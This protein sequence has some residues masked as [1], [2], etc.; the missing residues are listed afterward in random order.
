[1]AGRRYAL[2]T[3]A[4]SGIGAAMTRL[5]AARG[6]DVAVVAR[7][8]DRLEALATELRASGTGTDVYAADLSE[9]GGASVL[10][11]RINE[12][13]RQP[14]MLI[15]NAG[16]T[17][18]RGYAGTTWP[19]QR[20][21]LE[22]TVTTPALLTHA[23]LAAMLQ[24]SW[25][26]IVNISSIAALS[27]GG[28]GNTL[29]PAGKSFLLK[30]SQSLSAEVKARGVHVTAVLPGFVSTEFQSANG[31]P[32][33]GGPSRRFSQTPEEVAREAWTRNDKGHEIVV[34]GMA[35]K[36]AAGL[37]RVLPEPLMRALTRSA[38]EKYYVGD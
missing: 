6:F 36:L 32:M 23:F 35:P 28:K 34:P 5:A 16:A 13:G 14:D 37:M 27:S 21:F 2:V 31:I 9:P 33:S 29:Y 18:T 4:S 26:R 15:N 20:A 30:F 12:R 8:A 38:A 22:L 17:I 3:G 1:M 11:A 19:E 7:R 10:A 25:G 24:R